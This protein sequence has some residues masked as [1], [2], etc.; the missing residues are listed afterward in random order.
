MMQSSMAAKQARAR[1]NEAADAAW[2]ASL[3]AAIAAKLQ[4]WKL[5]GRSRSDAADC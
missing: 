2:Y 3:V 1:P 4:L 5:A